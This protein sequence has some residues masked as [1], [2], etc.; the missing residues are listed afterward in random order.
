[1]EQTFTERLRY[2]PDGISLLWE[3][4]KI[5]LCQLYGWKRLQSQVR[6]HLRELD[7]VLEGVQAETV[8]PVVGQ[9]GHE[10]ADLVCKKA[11]EVRKS[12]GKQKQDSADPSLTAKLLIWFPLTDNV[13]DHKWFSTEQL[14]YGADRS[15]IYK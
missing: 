8:I 15:I 11:Q 6:P 14:M 13:W 10:D 2:L 9:V 12:L 1:M 5:S 7:Q 3:N 4:L